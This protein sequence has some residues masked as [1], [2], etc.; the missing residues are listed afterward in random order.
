ML[1]PKYPHVTA[2]L[3]RHDSNAMSILGNC[4]R[5]ARLEGVPQD[6]LDIFFEE[7]TSGNYNH[8]LQTCMRWFECI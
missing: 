2:H 4:T 5:T 6:E 1:E 7:A 8:L 3:I